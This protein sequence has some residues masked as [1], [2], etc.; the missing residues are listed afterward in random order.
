MKTE[1]SIVELARQVA[2]C[3]LAA[4]GQTFAHEGIV[5]ELDDGSL[6]STIVNGARDAF[7]EDAN[8]TDGELQAIRLLLAT[9]NGQRDGLSFFGMAFV[10]DVIRCMAEDVVD[11]LCEAA[12][13]DLEALAFVRKVGEFR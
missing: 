1:L 12:S 4:Q 13:G 5:I 6:S 2:V 9:L 7:M 10:T 3:Y 8:D 11:L